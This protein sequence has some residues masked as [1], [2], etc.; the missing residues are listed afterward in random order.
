MKMKNTVTRSGVAAAAEGSFRVP[1]L[2]FATARLQERGLIN[3][4]RQGT[5]SAVPESTQDSG[6]STPEVRGTNRPTIYDMGRWALVIFDENLRPLALLPLAN[7]GKWDGTMRALVSFL[8]GSASQTEMAV[9]Y[10]KQTTAHFLT[11]QELT[12]GTK[13]AS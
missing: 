3:E 12:L 6:V 11:G 4:L 5:A 13:R 10:R 8:T 7:E 1:Q 9:T 2:G